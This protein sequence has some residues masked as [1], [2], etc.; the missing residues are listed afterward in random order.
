MEWLESEA[1]HE[2]AGDRH[3]RTKASRS[4][5][6]CTETEGHEQ[7]LQATVGSDGSH[8]L[9]HDFELPGLDGD[10]VEINRGENDPG[11]LQH[12]ESDAIPKADGGKLR[13]HSKKENCDSNR[14]TGT[15]H[16]APVWL[17]FEARQHA[18]Q[19]NDGQS[20]NKGGEPPMTEWI[21]NLGPLHPDLRA[22]GVCSATERRI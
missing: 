18:Q 14:R 19:D 7:H 10:V 4:L 17:K 2:S 5:D 15:R 13:R 9:F 1:D 3:G 20:R 11:N 22:N 21:V 6:E 8:R 16:G 12:T